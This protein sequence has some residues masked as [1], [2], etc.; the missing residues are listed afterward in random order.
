MRGPELFDIPDVFDIVDPR[1]RANRKGLIVLAVIMLGAQVLVR[2]G[3]YLLGHELQGPASW[4]I[5][6]L[7]IWLGVVALSK[8]LHDLGISAWWLLWAAIGMFVW[9]FIVSFAVVLTL[10]L[11]AVAPGSSGMMIAMTASFAPVMALTLWMH[12]AIGDAGG[13][14]F[15]PAPRVSGFSKHYST[16]SAGQPAVIAPP[17][18]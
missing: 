9:T 12:F 13:N 15:G 2:G 3:G 11:E 5:H 10:G 18:R 6:S 4:V 14:M 7:F 8:R 17:A 16:S 1:G